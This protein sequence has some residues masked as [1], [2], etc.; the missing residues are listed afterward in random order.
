M[1]NNSKSEKASVLLIALLTI[2]IVSLLCATSLYV[3]LQNTNTGMQTAGWQQALTGAE[4]GIDAAVRALNA[5]VSP[6]PGS[7]PSDA[8]S[9]S[10][11]KIASQSGTSLPTTEPSA[12]PASSA[13]SPPDSGHYNYLP[14]SILT[15]NVPNSGGEGAAKVATWVTIDTA[16]MLTSQDSH[17]QQ[18]YRVRSTAQTIYP[19]G[20]SILKRVSN[21]R[22]DSD[23]RNTLSMHFNRR[24]GSVL[25]PTR[26]IE[27]VL[28]PLLSSSIWGMGLTLQNALSMSGGGIVDHFNSSTTPTSTFLTSPSTYRST[29]YNETLVG[30]L[31]ANGSDLRSTYVYGQVSYSTTSAAPKNTTNVQGNPKLTTPFTSDV[32]TVS[33]PSWVTGAYLGYTGGS[34]PPF[35][36]T[37]GFNKAYIKIT[38]DFNVPA[39]KSVHF[40]QG[41]DSS[42]NPINNYTVWITGKYNTSGSGYVTQ[43]AGIT[44]TWYVDNS[45]TTSGGSYINPGSAA[46]ASFIGVAPNSPYSTQTNAAT[47][48]VS[49]GGSFIGTIEAPGYSGTV[50]G[51]GSFT[52]GIFANSLTISGG[53]SFHYDDALNNGGSTDPLIGNYAF[54]S[55]FED[56]SAPTHKDLKGNYVVY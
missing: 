32:P 14:S 2:T 5:Y 12:S 21:N 29:F 15:V 46:D 6:A 16:G 43:D 45:I 53:A 9:V 20:S 44:V 39:G 10:G 4:T 34:N 42:N 55:W 18:W 19:S 51:S 23:L 24:G 35:S 41:K 30:L 40:A 50:S 33:D 38:G 26:T 1:N 3:A 48:T 52:G 36:D 11:W 31:N 8:W 47:F 54:A 22:L 7:S 49:G 56:N 17:G 28:K 27:V 25:G 37:S 13:T